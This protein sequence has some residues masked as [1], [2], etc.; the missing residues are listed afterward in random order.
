[1]PPFYHVCY[2]YSVCLPAVIISHSVFE[3]TATVKNITR[4]TKYV[5]I[6]LIRRTSKTCLQVAALVNKNMF[7]YSVISDIFKSL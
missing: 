4:A 6:T 1:M 7:S 5:F 2:H 3:H